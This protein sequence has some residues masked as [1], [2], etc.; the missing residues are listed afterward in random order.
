MT[1]HPCSPSLPQR[2]QPTRMAFFKGDVELELF[3]LAG[4][5]GRGDENISYLCVN[6]PQPSPLLDDSAGGVGGF[7][8]LRSG[9]VCHEGRSVAWA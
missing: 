8:A 4:V 9:L 7:I 5:N 2:F 6:A 3:R 1:N